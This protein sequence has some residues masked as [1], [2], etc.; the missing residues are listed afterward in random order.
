MCV[1]KSGFFSTPIY[2]IA[3]CCFESVT[4]KRSSAL[5]HKIYEINR[6]VGGAIFTGQKGS[7]KIKKQN[8]AISFRGIF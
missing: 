1:K 6:C 3:T 4:V 2:F 7:P 8:L 5:Y